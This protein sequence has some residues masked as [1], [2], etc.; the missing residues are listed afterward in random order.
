MSTEPEARSVNELLGV[1]T[2][3]T[4]NA[5]AGAAV[6]PVQR[7]ARRYAPVY[8]MATTLDGAQD[9]VLK[10][11]AVGTVLFLGFGITNIS[12]HGMD[13]SVLA[14]MAFAAALM[15]VMWGVAVWFS[16]GF[17]AAVLRI[18]ADVAVDLAPGLSDEEKV[19]L[20]R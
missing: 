16:L 4:P 14:G 13:G 15:A 6:T 20:Q 10:L 7:V 11:S 8:D 3:S 18:S 9:I 1:D 19:S 17:A 12:G 2:A 5:G